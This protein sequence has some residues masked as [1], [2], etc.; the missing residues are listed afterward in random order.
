MTSLIGL[1]LLTVVAQAPAPAESC[2][3]HH[4]S[5]VDQRGD[6]AMGFAHQKTTHH[7][8]LTRDGGRIWAEA[9]TAEDVQTRDAI[10]SHF[11]HISQAFGAGN[12]EMPMFIHGQTPPGVT[13][14]KRLR[15]R[16]RYIPEGT[17]RGGQLRI[18]TTDTGGAT[19]D[20]RL[21]P[22]PDFRPPDRRPA[23]VGG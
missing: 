20:P 3:A 1:A 4:A 9:L 17:E 5:D 16:I 22:V 7:F 21:P 15:D 19:G 10:R 11:E 14:M 13:T 2:P 12:F 18:R 6:Q 8:Q 23:S